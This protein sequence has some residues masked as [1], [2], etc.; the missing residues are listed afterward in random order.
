MGVYLVDGPDFCGV[1][2]IPL[3]VWVPKPS[4]LRFCF[5]FVFGRNKVVRIVVFLG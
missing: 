1:S 5:H 3:V 4:S 2:S